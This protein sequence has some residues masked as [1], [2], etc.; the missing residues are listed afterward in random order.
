MI[1]STAAASRLG[2]NSATD[3]FRIVQ[4]GLS[5]IALH[6][7]ASRASIGMWETD[8]TLVLEIQDDGKGVTEEQATSPLS[9]GLIG[10]RE[11][12]EGLHGEMSVCGKPGE[13]T[14]LTVTI[15]LPASGTLA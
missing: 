5:N 7:Q 14:T 2:V 15:P 9:L 3:L 10:I 12:A 1:D 11:R 4:E 8:S 6:A 13:G